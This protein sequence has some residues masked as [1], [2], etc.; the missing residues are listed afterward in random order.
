MTA[1]EF[2]QTNSA[3]LLTTFGL[4]GAALAACLTCAL[5]S[6]CSKIKCCGF[7]C[8]RQVISEGEL[9]NASVELGRT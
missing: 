5:K 4:C 2:V 9:A 7:E 8:D 6:R 3:F 1:S